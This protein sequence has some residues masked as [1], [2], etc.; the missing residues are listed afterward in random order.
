MGFLTAQDKE[1]QQSRRTGQ[2]WKSGEKNLKKSFICFQRGRDPQ[3]KMELSLVDKIELARSY[4]PIT[5]DE[6]QIN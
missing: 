2:E 3:T 5:G 1:K 6:F 4:Q